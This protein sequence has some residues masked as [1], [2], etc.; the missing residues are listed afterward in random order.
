MV[1]R[2]RGIARIRTLATAHGDFQRFSESGEVLLSA[3][4]LMMKTDMRE[5][6]ASALFRSPTEIKRRIKR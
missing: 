1:C 4:H 3:L 5:Y 2:V 6:S